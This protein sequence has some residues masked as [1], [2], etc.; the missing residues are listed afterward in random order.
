MKT[1]LTREALS[2]IAHRAAE[3]YKTKFD[4]R[5][6]ATVRTNLAVRFDVTEMGDVPDASTVVNQYLAEHPSYGVKA[7]KAE[8]PV[9]SVT[10][11]PKPRTLGAAVVMALKAEAAKAAK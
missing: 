3:A 9:P 10:D 4:P 11:A 8:A 7:A 6:W 2:A 5:H 1:A